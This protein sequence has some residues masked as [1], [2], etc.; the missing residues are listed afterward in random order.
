MT[1]AT[2]TKGNWLGRARHV[3]VYLCCLLA[4]IVGTPDAWWAWAG[5]HT[6]FETAE[7]KERPANDENDDGKENEEGKRSTEDLVRHMRLRR[8]ARS[9]NPTNSWLAHLPHHHGAVAGYSLP[10]CSPFERGALLPLR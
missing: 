4:L 5:P 7:G 8:L 1:L 2:I 6:S 10:A 9:S 3:L